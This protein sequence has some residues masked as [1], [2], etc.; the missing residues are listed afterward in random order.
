MLAYPVSAFDVLFFE[1]LINDPVVPYQ[2]K[3][4]YSLFSSSSSRYYINHNT[5][6][7][8]ITLTTSPHAHHTENSPLALSPFPPQ[9]L[10]NCP[11]SS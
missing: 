3:K 10:K 8:P 2:H 6:F 1:C 9:L 11:K 7:L 5:R 4:R